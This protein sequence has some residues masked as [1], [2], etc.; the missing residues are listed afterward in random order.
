VE[1]LLNN[2]RTLNQRVLLIIVLILIADFFSLIPFLGYHPNGIYKLLFAQVKKSKSTR[3]KVHGEY[4]LWVQEK[5]N[6]IDVGWM[7]ARKDSGFLKVFKNGSVLFEFRT[8]SARAHRA[9]FETGNYQALKLQYGSLTDLSDQHKTDIYLSESSQKT[10]SVFNKVDS[11]YV[12]GDIHGQFDTL[13]NLLKNAKI[14]DTNFNWIANQ[15][16]LVALGDLFGRGNDVTRTLWFL[17]KLEREAEKQGGRVHILLG[18]HEIMTFGN[19]LRYVAGKE[20]MIANTHGVSYAEMYSP[21]R[22]VLGKW[23]A[24]KPAI[25]KID[26]VLFAHGG[27]VPEYTFSNRSINDSLRAFLQQ[28]IFY[29]LL[30]DSIP[31]SV[32]SM[33]FYQRV[34][35]FY[36]WNSV[37]WHRGYVLS[38]TL[39]QDL[40]KILKKFKCKLHVIAHT[41]VPTISELY[42]GKIFAVDLR[43]PATEMLLLVRSRK[44]KYKRFK[45]KL[46]GLIK[47]FQQKKP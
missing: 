7:T 2:S 10:K 36:G 34:A 32:D 41:P 39:E 46:N 37:F 44:N 28:D 26:K 30:Q 24:Q 15:K 5:Q 22:S 18:N 42:N 14:I 20:N 38:D 27:L 40:Q 35:F 1:L 25:L 19:D 12:L 29:T 11:I 21:R 23:L 13:T 3:F 31:A 45:V 4:G 16:H 43:K 8:P 47:P 33:Q 9:G 6:Q 17:Y